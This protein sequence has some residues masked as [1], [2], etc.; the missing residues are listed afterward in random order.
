MIIWYYRLLLPGNIKIRISRRY[1]ARFWYLPGPARATASNSGS[2]T[3]LSTPKPYWIDSYIPS[4]NANWSES[5]G[6]LLKPLLA[7]RRKNVMKK[8]FAEK[9]EEL[10]DID[11]STSIR[12]RLPYD[13][14][15]EIQ[16]YRHDEKLAK[17]FQHV[18]SFSKR[19]NE[20]DWI[21]GNDNRN[22]CEILTINI[23]GSFDLHQ[24]LLQII[25]NID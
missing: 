20:I 18:I 13:D 11:P 14:A 21:F 3:P 12:C 4:S 9:K 23:N 24:I 25:W 2:K 8:L 22:I 16:Q 6:P 1:S 15:T 5:Y 17:K 10:L 7:C 19:T